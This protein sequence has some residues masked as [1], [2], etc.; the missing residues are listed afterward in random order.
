MAIGNLVLGMGVPLY[1]R[2]AKSLETATYENLVRKILEMQPL[3]SIFLEFRN[4]RCIR[5]AVKVILLRSYGATCEGLYLGS[6]WKANKKRSNKYGSF[7]RGDAEAR[8]FQLLLERMT[9]NFVAGLR[10]FSAFG[11]IRM[12]AVS[13]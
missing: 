1:T 10:M 9:V 4:L 3:R 12:L 11:A 8:R 13:C 7:H 2:F 5:R 6:M